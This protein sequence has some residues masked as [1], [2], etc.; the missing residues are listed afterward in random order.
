M[1]EYSKNAK[2]IFEG[3]YLNGQRKGKSKEF[4]IS[5]IHFIHNNFLYKIQRRPHVYENEDCLNEENNKHTG[6]LIFEGKYL[7]GKGMEREKNITVMEN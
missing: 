6:K 5:R 7:N 1:K 3:E 2:I 4:K